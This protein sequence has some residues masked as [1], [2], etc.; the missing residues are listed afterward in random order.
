VIDGGGNDIWLLETVFVPPFYLIHPPLPLLL[1][2]PQLLFLVE[3]L[4][5]LTL[6]FLFFLDHRSLSST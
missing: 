5:V 4:Q 2:P 1:L 3:E 6:V